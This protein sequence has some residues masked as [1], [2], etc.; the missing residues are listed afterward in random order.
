MELAD[1]ERTVAEHR[2]RAPGEVSLDLAH[3]MPVLEH[4]PRAV[5]HAMVIAHGEPVLARY[6]DAFLAAR[7]GACRDTDGIR[8]AYHSSPLGDSPRGCCS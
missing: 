6:R 8:L 3:Y 5:M 2:R 4:R 1:R 7:P